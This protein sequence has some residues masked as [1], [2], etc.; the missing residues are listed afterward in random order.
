M[1]EQLEDPHWRN[2]SE[3]FYALL[4]LAGPGLDSRSALTSLLKSAPEKS[5]EIKLALIKL[6]E[7]ENAFL[8]EYAKDYRITN[9]PLGEESGE[10]YADLIAAVSSLKDIRSLD[11]LLGAIRTGTMVTDALAEFGLAAVDPVIQKLNNR[12][13]RL[14]AVI[15]LGQML[16]PRNYPKVSDPASREKIKKAL[17]NATSDQSDS[18]RLLAIEGLAKLG[19]ADVIPFIENAAINDPYDQSEFIRGLG[20][21]PDKK[22]FYPVRE[23]AKELLEKLK[24]K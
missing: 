22:N 6:L 20:G 16:E 15:T 8:E 4:A 11:A 10:Y 19:D 13:E 1:I 21:K 9:V 17:I 18:V 2:R 24:K 7:R 3:A 14:P 23:R 12:E 5:D